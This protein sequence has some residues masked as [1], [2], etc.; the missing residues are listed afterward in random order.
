MK[1]LNIGKG[2]QQSLSAAE[3]LNEKLYKLSNMSGTR[4][5]AYLYDCLASNEKSLANSIQEIQDSLI[6]NL[7][8]MA[9]IKLTNESEDVFEDN[10]DKEL[11][12]ELGLKVE[13]VLKWRI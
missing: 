3:N 5:V 7:R 13:K 11:R 2:L 4:F 6:Q 1:L 10:F 8:K 9:D 12:P